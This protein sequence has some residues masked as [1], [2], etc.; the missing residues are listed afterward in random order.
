MQRKFI[1]LHPKIEKIDW[2]DWEANFI[3]HFKADL[4]DLKKTEKTLE[5]F[6]ALKYGETYN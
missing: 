3:L 1:L 2:P 4:S 5:V 6:T